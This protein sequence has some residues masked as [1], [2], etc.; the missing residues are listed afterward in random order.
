MPYPSF[1]SFELKVFEQS[2]MKIWQIF[3]GFGRSPP[4]PYARVFRASLEMM[5]AKRIHLGKKKRVVP[6]CVRRI[7]QKLTHAAGKVSKC[8]KCRGRTSKPLVRVQGSRRT[9]SQCA[10]R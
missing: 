4:R 8:A 5:V 2:D 10:A 1:Y 6:R 7:G 3:N 9:V